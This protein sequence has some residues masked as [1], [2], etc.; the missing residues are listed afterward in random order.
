[1]EHPIF[2][3]GQDPPELGTIRRWNVIQNPKNRTELG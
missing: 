1:M 3:A 2:D